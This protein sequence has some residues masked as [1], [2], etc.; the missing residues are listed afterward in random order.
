MH[1]SILF[2]YEPKIEKFKGVRFIVL[3]AIFALY[4]IVQLFLILEMHKN[5]DYFFDIQQLITTES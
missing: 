5:R 4:I 2:G 3:R 1:N